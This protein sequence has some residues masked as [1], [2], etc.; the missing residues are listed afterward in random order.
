MESGKILIIDDD[1]D[2]LATARL[3]LKQE[4]STVHTLQDP[5][6]INPRVSSE[7]YDAIV[8]DM[9]FRKGDQDGKGGLYWLERILQIDPD[10][11]V[12]LITAYGDLELAVQA[13]KMGASD[14]V[15][16]PWKNEK[17]LE[18][19]VKGLADKKNVP[20]SNQ[21]IPVAGRGIITE[22][23]E[24]VGQSAAMR[25]VFNQIRQ[26]APTD[27]SVL[28]TG[29]NGTGKDLVA[30]A[31]HLQSHRKARPFVAVDLGAISESL[32]ESEL[33]GHVKGAFTDANTDKTGW[34]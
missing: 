14:F 27:A 23:V 11:V 20:K 26:V 7:S 12:I 6:L 3:L 10:I 28:V 4:F 15:L 2:I 32:V 18:A 30:R 5:T 9:N 24:I 29:E 19:I 8:L 31:L 13:I 17:L 34:F 25:H 22:K 33:F 16:K 1:P 21:R